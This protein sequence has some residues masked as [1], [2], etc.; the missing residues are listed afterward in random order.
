[1]AGTQTAWTE[2]RFECFA[3]GDVAASFGTSGI[4]NH[5]TGLN[6]SETLNPHR[7]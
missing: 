5:T 7:D 4:N 3:S 6:S 2:A 1:M